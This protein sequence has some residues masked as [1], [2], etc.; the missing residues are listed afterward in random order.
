MTDK[1]ILENCNGNVGLLGARRSSYIAF[2]EHR[3]KR[4]GKV[5]REPGPTAGDHR[6]T[7]SSQTAR[8]NYNV[9]KVLEQM[10]KI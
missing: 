3:L 10:K 5:E 6:G 9:M 8:Q 7:S 2:G 4:E 1:T